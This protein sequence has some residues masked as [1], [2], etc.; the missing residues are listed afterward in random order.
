V[1][2]GPEPNVQPNE[3][4]VLPCVRVSLEREVEPIEKKGHSS[5]CFQ[6]IMSFFRK[7][8]EKILEFFGGFLM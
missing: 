3:V 4:C 5:G 6:Q 2:S 1:H 8:F 7:N